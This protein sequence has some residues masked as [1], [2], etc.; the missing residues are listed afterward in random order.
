MNSN[1]GNVASVDPSELLDCGEA[2]KLLRQE[3]QTLAAWRCKGRGPEYVKIG[4]SVFYRRGAISSWLAQQ[5][6]KPGA[7][8]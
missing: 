2:A 4:R 1:Q 3:M 8:A 5:V 6:V 7:A